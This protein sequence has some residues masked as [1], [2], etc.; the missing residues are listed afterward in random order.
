MI[1]APRISAGI[2]EER[3][4]MAGQAMMDRITI[5]NGVSRLVDQLRRRTFFLEFTIIFGVVS[6]LLIVFT[7]LVL[8]SYLAN[9]MRRKETDDVVAEVTRETSA[10]VVLSLQGQDLSA[11]LEGQTLEEFD[12][13]IRESVLSPRTVRVT[14]WNNDQTIIYSSYPAITGSTLA[15]AEPLQEALAG[16]T[17]AFVNRPNGDVEGAVTASPVM[18]VYAPLRLSEGGEIVGALEVYRD[19]GPIAA[20]ITKTQRSVY[21]G[22]AVALAFLYAALHLLVKRRSNLIREQRRALE[23]QTEELK[24]SY[25]SI[26]AVLCAA[27]DLRDNVTHGHAQRVSEIASVVAWQMGLR[28]ED[29]RRIEKAAILHDIGKIGVADAVLGKP[30]PLTENEWGEM[31][32]HPEL[33]Y[34]MLQGIDYLRDAAEVVYAHHERYDGS[35]YPRGLKGDEI[36]T[37]ARIFAVVDAYEAMTSHRPYRKALP[38]RQAIEEI[39]RNANSQ[40]DPEVV[41]AFLDA[42]KRG[43]LDNE[44][45]PGDGKASST[46]PE[47]TKRSLTAAGD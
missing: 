20:Q 8:G 11:P 15:L 9:D 25:D 45:K 13:L 33:G 7:G 31:K 32:R 47:P 17:T 1:P 36:P 42:E 3:K 23:N 4:V 34:R 28:K 30:G 26:V 40:F 21:I 46:V 6:L 24:N 22:T 38:H 35:G 16:D 10:A 44:S 18:Q 39:V 19:Y 27:L 5:R 37:G 2:S 43:L 29:V 41:R 14:L 12:T